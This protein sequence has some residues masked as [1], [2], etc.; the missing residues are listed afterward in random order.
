M[1]AAGIIAEYNPCH[2]GHRYHM[3]AT[4]LESGADCIVAVMSGNFMQR[5]VPAAADKFFRAECALLNGADLVLE[6]PVIYAT[7]SAERFAFAGVSLLGMTRSVR[8]LSFGTESEQRAPLNQLADI[9]SS[10]SEEYGRL[11]R[12]FR[13]GGLNAAAAR[14]Q[15]LCLLYPKIP[16]HDL[17]SKPN[18]ILAVEYLKA[19][20]QGGYDLT[21]L[22]VFRQ[23]PDYHDTTLC[24]SVSSASAIRRAIA[25]Q[26][27]PAVK[28]TVTPKTYE[29]FAKEYRHTFP[30]GTDSLNPFLSYALLSCERPFS[31]YA[32]LDEKLANRIRNLL[33]GNDP[34]SFRELCGTLKCKNYTHS[35]ISRALLHILLNITKEDVLTCKT[36]EY[37]RVL[38]FNRT[39]SAFLRRAAKVSDIPFITNPAHAKNVLSE[40]G[41]RCFKK[42]V[43]ASKLYQLLIQSQ[44]KTTVKDDYRRMPVIF[45]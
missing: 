3:E 27:L 1:L 33:A 7:A 31:D 8:I 35:H 24:D 36:P 20:R 19:I 29:L 15:A 44:Y 38:G 37:A 2:L 6:L 32:D 45:R 28:H 22:A 5:G 21:P 41:F 43:Y 26:G 39:G 11:Y 25:E 10:E 14:E 23:G 30:I 42:D 13:S 18:N 4:R 17:L 9:L 12:R 34:L 40:T 16:V